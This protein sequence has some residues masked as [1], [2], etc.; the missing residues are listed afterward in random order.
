MGALSWAGACPDRF[1]GGKAPRC[2]VTWALHSRRPPLAP[3][4]KEKKL[5]DSLTES[6]CS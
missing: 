2:V 1:P 5:S 6:F 4:I 3:G